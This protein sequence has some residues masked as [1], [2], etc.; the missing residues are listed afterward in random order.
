VKWLETQTPPP[1][2]KGEAK[3]TASFAE[4]SAV[5]AGEGGDVTLVW[6]PKGPAPGAPPGKY[7][8]RTTRISRENFLISA[9][10]GPEPT[11]AVKDKAEL[12]VDETVRF[13]GQAKRLGNKLDLGFSIKG[14]DG[15]G[16]S[17]YKDGKR[18]PVTYKVLAK[19]GAV[20]AQGKMNYG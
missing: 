1:R 16:L 12:K 19:D 18:V 7:R 9:A 20:L 2:A 6:D 10:A 8:V 4:G 11:L 14:K 17:V 15:R 13:D 3:V 5:L